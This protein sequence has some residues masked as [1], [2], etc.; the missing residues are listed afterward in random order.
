[1]NAELL[2][3]SNAKFV[4]HMFAFKA[5]DTEWEIQYDNYR[6]TAVETS[7][8]V[9]KLIGNIL[10]GT[11]YCLREYPPSNRNEMEA[12]RKLKVIYHNTIQTQI[13]KAAFLF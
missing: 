9:K 5:T 2:I 11:V 7:T 6:A 3:T 1:M 8:R 13:P 4:N 10:Q 12:I